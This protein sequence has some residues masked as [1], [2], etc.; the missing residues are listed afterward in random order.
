MTAQGGYIASM[1]NQTR[2]GLEAFDNQHDFERLA[3]D[4]LNG[5][6]YSGV[7]PM[8]PAGGADGGQDIR[9]RDG[10]EPGLAFVTLDKKIREKFRRDLAKHPE[11]SG[12]IALF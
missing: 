2:Q 7:E 11:A 3:A 10:A 12:V 8:A 5:L 6:G 4:V 1:L 9:F